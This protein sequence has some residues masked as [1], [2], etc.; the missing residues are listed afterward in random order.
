MRVAVA[1]EVD[2]IECLLCGGVGIGEEVASG[3]PRKREEDSKNTID[4]REG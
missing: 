2:E 1:G 3:G 4:E